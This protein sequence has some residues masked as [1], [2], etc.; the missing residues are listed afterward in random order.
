MPSLIRLFIVLLFLAGL[1]YAGMLALVAFVQP[2]DREITVQIPARQ[3]FG[4]E[5]GAGGPVDLMPDADTAAPVAPA[6]P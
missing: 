1:A 3:L 2:R 6:S 5:A 4:N